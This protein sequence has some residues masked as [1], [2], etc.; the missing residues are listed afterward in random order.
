MLR[1]TCSLEQQNNRIRDEKMEQPQIILSGSH[2]I[3]LQNEE[4][5]SVFE[6]T[7]EQAIDDILAA[8][9]KNNKQAIYHQLKIN[10]GI[11]KS[12]IPRKIEDFATAIEQIFGS[13]AKLL[14]IKI[15]ER[16]HS[17]YKDFYYTPKKEELN[18][19][20]FIYNLQLYVQ[21]KD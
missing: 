3:L 8:L 19:V 12:E 10:Y 4:T 9:G 18:F 11:N 6:N 15:I 7:L 16:L 1:Y 21:L 20:E 14:E 2:S 5:K 13:V 17:K